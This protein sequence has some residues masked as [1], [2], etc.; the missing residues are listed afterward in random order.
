MN[1]LIAGRYVLFDQLGEGA[2]AR[3]YRAWDREGQQWI[4]LKRMRPELAVNRTL[5]ARF[6]IEAEALSRLSHPHVVQVRDHGVDDRCTWIAMELVEGSSLKKWMEVHGPMPP[7][8]A[9][10]VLLQVCAGIAAA[11]DRGII[12]RDIKP[13]NVLVDPLGWC[14]VV[15][16]GIARFAA[17]QAS[18][19]RTGLT[20]GTWGYMAP[21]QQSDAKRADTRADVHALGATLLALLSGRDPLQPGRDLRRLGERVP[22][23]LRWPITRATL[24]EPDHRQ[25]SVAR[26]ARTLVHLR[27]QLPAPPPATPGLHLAIARVAVAAPTTV[28]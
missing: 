11:H 15:D 18:V 8:L 24:P 28:P 4:A 12:H 23:L 2:V 17:G 3:V 13:Q 9:V 25:P 6:R 14:R 27:D 5:Q 19:T 26:L 7:Q 10:D 1:E 20:M 21:E 22:E 16:F